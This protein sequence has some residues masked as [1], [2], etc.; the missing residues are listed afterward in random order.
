MTFN[1][2]FKSKFLDNL[3]S[4]SVPDTI[5][6]LVLAC[7]LGFL[8]FFVYKK[9]F[10]GVMYQSSFGVTLIALTLISTLVILAVSSNIVLSLGMVGALSVVRFRAAIKDPLDLAF[11]FWAIAV[12][13]VL[14]AGMIPLAVIASAIISAVLLLFA[15]RRSPRSDPYILVVACADREAESAVDGALAAAVKKRQVKSKTVTPDMIELNYEIRLLS[16]DTA[17][18][19]HLADMPGVK[20]AV[21][22]SYNGDYTG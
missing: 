20:N 8:I 12:G 19:N 2:I 7:V 4:T 15:S 3:N 14:A 22:V 18:L 16:D 10:R 5:L 6:A 11:L 1:D 9:T 21:L 13:I 17:F